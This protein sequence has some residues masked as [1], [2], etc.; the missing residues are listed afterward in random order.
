LA[1][2]T[3]NICRS[4]AVERL[5]RQAFGSTAPVSSAGTHALVG[6]PVH[7][8]MAELIANRGADPG[9]FAA[10][11]ITE[12]MVEDADLVLALTREHRA[13]VAELHPPAVRRIFTLREFARFAARVDPDLLTARTPAGRLSQLIPLARTQRGRHP[14]DP[15]EDDVVDPYGHDAGTYRRS[16]AVLA[17]AVDT[18]VEIVG[19]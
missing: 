11:R 12:S 1:V 13:D 5:L 4:P 9:H 6:A 8:P 15:A 18:V 3:G 14:V 7:S 10:R 2:C 16:F 17:A 19:T